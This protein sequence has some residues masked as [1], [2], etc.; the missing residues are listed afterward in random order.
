MLHLVYSALDPAVVP[1]VAVAV[2]AMGKVIVTHMLVARSVAIR[3]L[4]S[5][6]CVRGVS[7]SKLGFRD[8]GSRTVAVWLRCLGVAEPGCDR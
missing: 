7:S 4:V 6:V 1:P 8:A 3:F 5:K 2:M